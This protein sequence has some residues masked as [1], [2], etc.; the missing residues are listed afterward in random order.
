MLGDES[1]LFRVTAVIGPRE[2][3]TPQVR[4]AALARSIRPHGPRA[5]LA[6]APGPVRARAWVPAA[7]RA[8]AGPLRTAAIAEALPRVVPGSLAMHIRLL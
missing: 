7:P 6:P 3:R 4:A 5:R 1:P 2:A 8:P